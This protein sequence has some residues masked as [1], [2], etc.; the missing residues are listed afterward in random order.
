M[1]IIDSYLH[2]TDG[3]N[4]PVD[5]KQRS[6]AVGWIPTGT[7][8]GLSGP[9]SSGWFQDTVSRPSLWN[10]F[11]DLDKNKPIGSRL[12]DRFDA[13]TPFYTRRTE[14]DPPLAV[15]IEDRIGTPS[16]GYAKPAY[17][18][19]HVDCSQLALQLN[20]TRYNIMAGAGD[21]GVPDYAVLN[22]AGTH[23]IA[24]TLPSV[25]PVSI[26]QTLGEA[27][28]GIPRIIGNELWRHP[29]FSSLGGEYLNYVFGITP[30]IADISAYVHSSKTVEEF[31]DRLRRNNGRTIRR[32]LS[33][34]KSSTTTRTTLPVGSVSPAP[35]G[36]RNWTTGAKEVSTTVE[37]SMW[38]SASYRVDCPPIRDNDFQK[39]KEGFDAY[40]VTP[41]A[42]TTWQLTPWSWLLDW[43]VNFDDLFTNISFL[44]RKGVNLHY[45]YVMAQTEVKKTWSFAGTYKPSGPASSAPL[46]FEWIQSTVTKQR[47]KATPL[48][49]G[50]TYNG[51]TTSQKGILA[52]LGISRLAF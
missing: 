30:L 25:P 22:A 13:G 35:N 2:Y 43:V 41:N 27:R 11:K 29:K 16:Y 19:P 37:N 45:G 6:Y 34:G 24:E 50:A 10:S 39:M 49:F 26:A 40:G 47:A 23:G 17:I 28:E 42:I 14:I 48:G 1:A 20:A 44:G 12:Q 7:F 33:F 8:G 52:A 4:R 38:F 51:L 15:V 36:A 32:G 3:T 9:F 46:N 5:R 21:D 31:N 18:Y